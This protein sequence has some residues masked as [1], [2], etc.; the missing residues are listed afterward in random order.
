[1]K[2]LLAGVL[3]SCMMLSGSAAFAAE[4]ESGVIQLNWED[5][6]AVNE[7]ADQD[8]LSQGNFV[9]FDE[10]DCMM[11]V[12]DALKEVELTDEDVDAGYI[13][14]FQDDDQT[15]TVA[16]M[17]VDA[18]SDLEEYKEYL[19]GSDGVE[20]VSELLVN[21]NPAVSY[22][23]PEND[24]SC[25]AFAT[26]SGKILEFTFVPMSDENFQGV[27]AFMGASIQPEDTSLET[28]AAE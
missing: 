9:V 26:E 14:Y 24:A 6:Q 4:T 21:G 3:V 7:M 11:W 16:V 18:E 2:K 5:I 13:G 20:E 28:E 23:M 25:L 8:I 27:V 15:A 22:D 17:L 1:M 12:P 19:E 10:I